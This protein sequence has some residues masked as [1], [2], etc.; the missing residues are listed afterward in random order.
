MTPDS[1]CA[2]C[3]AFVAR[4]KNGKRLMHTRTVDED[5]TTIQL[6]SSGGSGLSFPVLVAGKRAEICEGSDLGARP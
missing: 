4:D 3:G 5:S 6:V 1:K 2:I